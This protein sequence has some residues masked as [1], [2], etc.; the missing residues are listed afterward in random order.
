MRLKH[1]WKRQGN[2]KVLGN[3]TEGQ[4]PLTWRGSIG[5]PGPQVGFE[6]SGPS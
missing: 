6:V 2:A 3:S 5:L 4:S 1:L